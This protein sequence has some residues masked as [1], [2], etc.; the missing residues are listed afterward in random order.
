MI[1]QRSPR[2]E[3]NHVINQSGLLA[4]LQRP[5]AFHRAFAQISGSVTAGLFYRHIYLSGHGL[6]RLGTDGCGAVELGKVRRFC[7]SVRRGLDRYGMAWIILP[8]HIF[9]G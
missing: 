8:T 6:L 9:S 5:I 2:T 7:G 4:A 1:I 3:K